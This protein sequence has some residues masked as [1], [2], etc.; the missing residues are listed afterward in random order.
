M[1]NGNVI[2]L[3]SVGKVN[4]I[5]GKFL[6]LIS[7]HNF[8]NVGYIKKKLLGLFTEYFNSGL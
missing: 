6:F 3:L 2:F 1:G 4:A 7:G 8:V 5:F